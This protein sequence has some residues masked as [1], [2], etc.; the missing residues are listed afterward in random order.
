MAG[1]VPPY[2][3]GLRHL[4]IRRFA[5]VHPRRFLGFRGWNLPVGMRRLVDIVANPFGDRSVAP[6]V[7]VGD[8]AP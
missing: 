7:V 2:A 3:A 1:F 8:P 5:R 6:L 4:S